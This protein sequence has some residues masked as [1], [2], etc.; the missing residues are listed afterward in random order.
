MA[1]ID[2]TP[3]APM[4]RESP[5][6][7]PLE[8]LMVPTSSALTARST[9]LEPSSDPLTAFLHEY[10][11]VELLSRWSNAAPPPSYPAPPPPV[12]I[13]PS[14]PT[15]VA[16]APTASASIS[17]TTGGSSTDTD[18]YQPAILSA[19]MN[20][21][22]SNGASTAAAIVPQAR[23]RTSAPP[24]DSSLL[25]DR[26]SADSSDATQPTDSFEMNSMVGTT[27]TSSRLKSFDVA[28]LSRTPEFIDDDDDDED[29]DDAAA[30]LPYARAKVPPAAIQHTDRGIAWLTM[31]MIVWLQD[32]VWGEEKPYWV[33]DDEAPTCFGCRLRFK[34]L[35]RKVHPHTR[36]PTPAARS[37]RTLV[38]YRCAHTSAPCLTIA[39]LIGC[40]GVASLPVHVVHA[41]ARFPPANQ[42]TNRTNSSDG[43]RSL[44]AASMCGGVFCRACSKSRI[45]H[46]LYNK[47]QLCCKPCL[48]RAE[49]AAV[50]EAAAQ[51]PAVPGISN[52][53]IR[54]RQASLQ[55]PIAGM[56]AANVSG[57]DP[58]HFEPEGLIQLGAI[59]ASFQPLNLRNNNESVVRASALT[60]IYRQLEPT[61]SST[62][63]AT[64]GSSNA[65]RSKA[66]GASRTGGTNSGS[67]ANGNGAA[68]NGLAY[69]GGTSVASSLVSTSSGG[70]SSAKRASLQPNDPTRECPLSWLDQRL[71]LYILLY[72][73]EV[74]YSMVSHVRASLSIPPSLTH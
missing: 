33:P 44:L 67:S 74:R 69:N 34:L 47:P 24:L 59:A 53:I 55:V 23:K 4:A 72:L 21:L 8:A 66:S 22:R 57:H 14:R 60:G 40:C 68:S 37:N 9:V 25:A 63:G 15:N 52:A 2:A 31:M 5:T 1:T 28:S 39:G 7:S 71:I 32:F 10:D 62:T 65:D 43:V 50:A 27:H 3:P 16:A 56:G 12:S 58:I 17:S 38:Q 49:A 20:L 64:K 6:S 18:E 35:R 41:L 70:L 51:R 42:P 48:Q 46:K 54:S 29:D 73:P 36:A 26:S 19:A 11:D 30:V 13:A 61:T 45:V